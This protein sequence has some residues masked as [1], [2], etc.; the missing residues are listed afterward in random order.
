[1]YAQLGNII[2]QG[3]L[4]FSAKSSNREANLAEH[5]LIDGKP[6]L[7]RVGDKLEEI[8]LTMNLH[9]SFCSPEAVI[10]SL[11]S[12]RASSE[13]LPYIEGNGSFLGTFVIRSIRHEILKTNAFGDI[14]SASVDVSLIEY[15]DPSPAATKDSAAKRN[16][17]GNASNNPASFSGPLASSSEAAAL[18]RAPIAVAA[19]GQAVTGNLSKA[20]QNPTR[21]ASILADTTRR[22]NKMRTDLETLR[23]GLS[24]A[25]YVYQS[26]QRI[27]NGATSAL[28]AVNNVDDFVK[29]GN[30][31]GAISA[32]D[33][34]IR[35]SG[36]LLGSSS[37]LAVVSSTRTN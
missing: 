24:N 26:A 15:A 35:A 6:R 22:L 36:N 37:E 9:V 20:A 14:V 1:M 28:A 16:G 8:N 33:E 10:A 3:L 25:Q 32:N 30:L 4:G 18:A 19:E 12:A 27:Q 13:V 7:Q 23:T 2:F 11:E 31:S 21:E 34:L 5:Q 17:F 29:A